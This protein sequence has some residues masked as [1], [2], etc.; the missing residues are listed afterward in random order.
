MRSLIKEGCYRAAINLS[1]KLLSVYGQGYGKIN[2]PSKHSP[3]SL[4]LWFTRLSLLV[5]LRR[6]DILEVE[7]APFQNLDKPDMYFIFYPELYGTRSGS[8]ACF[9]FRLLIAEIPMY[10]GKG[11]HALD[12]LYALLSIIKKIIRNLNNGLSEEGGVAKFN[13]EEKID[14]IHLWKARKSRTMIS[15]VNCA[16]SIKNYILAT[17]VLEQLFDSNEWKKGQSETIISAIGR[18]YLCLG[19]VSAAEKKFPPKVENPKAENIKDLVDRGLISVSQNAFQEALSFFEKAAELDPSNIMLLNNIAV[20]LLYTGKLEAAVE[21]MDKMV[22]VQNPVRSL[23]EAVLLNMCTL[24]ELHTTHSKQSKLHLL[25]QLNRYNG[26]STNIQC[27][28]LTM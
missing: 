16:L 28:K 22:T 1:G 23:Q 2:H 3:S 11:K 26:D 8:M 18:I 6:A 19:D 24:Y 17:E 7:S 10:C 27:L 5:K 21:V 14:A 20:C 25:R 9:A 12:N 4:Q 13:G 15:I